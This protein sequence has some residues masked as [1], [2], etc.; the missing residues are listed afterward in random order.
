MSRHINARMDDFFGPYCRPP[1]PFMLLM[2]AVGTT[3]Q[4]FVTPFRLNCTQCRVDLCLSL[5]Q[6]TCYACVTP[7]PTLGSDLGA[8]AFPPA[9][10]LYQ[11]FMPIQR[12]LSSGSTML[13]WSLIDTSLAVVATFGSEHRRRQWQCLQAS[14]RVERRE[15]TAHQYRA[16]IVHSKRKALAIQFFVFKSH[17]EL[18]KRLASKR[19]CCSHTPCLPSVFTCHGTI[20]LTL[21]SVGCMLPPDSRSCGLHRWICS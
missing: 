17:A 5:L 4:R 1:P 9:T 15:T 7:S 20:Q 19:H 3:T 2:H 14:L 10:P 12:Y 8:Q 13:A 16:Q 21:G 18:H 6:R 11:A